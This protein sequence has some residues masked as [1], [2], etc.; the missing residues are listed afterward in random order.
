MEALELMKTLLTSQ[1]ENEIMKTCDKYMELFQKAAANILANQGEEVPQVCLN[2]VLQAMLKSTRSAV[3]RRYSSPNQFN[4]T[5][6]GRKM[7]RRTIKVARHKPRTLKNLK[8]DWYKQIG[9][10]YH[11]QESLE[12]PSM[13]NPAELGSETLAERPSSPVLEN[14]ID[15]N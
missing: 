14:H 2:S 11:M 7:T 10:D 4:S 9:K 1:F 5:S 12:E 15:T 8:M 6:R 3:T 13:E